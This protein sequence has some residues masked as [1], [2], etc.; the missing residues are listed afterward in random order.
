MSFKS[1]LFIYF[2]KFL[3]EYV[4]LVSAVQQSESVMHIHKATFF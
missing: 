1:P 2:L 4:V 3:L